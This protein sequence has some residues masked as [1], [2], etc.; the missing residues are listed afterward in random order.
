MKKEIVRREFLKLKLNGRLYKECINILFEKYG[1]K[2]S[3][4]TLKRWN[5]KFNQGNW[6]LRDTST[7][8]NKVYYKF[9]IEDL[10]DVIS[11]RKKTGFS[12]YQLKIKLEEK[13]IFISK[14]MITKVVRQTGLSRGNKMEGIKLKWVRFER[15]NP[16]SM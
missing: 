8:P 13:G 1:F 7:K 14:S 3:K 5:K 11:L 10:E 6:N 2:V 15:D 16:N 9:S 12:N 4:S